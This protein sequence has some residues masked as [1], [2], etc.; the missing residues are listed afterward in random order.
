[1]RPRKASLSIVGDALIRVLASPASLAGSVWPAMMASMIVRPLVPMMSEITESSLILASSRVFCR[2]W[3]WLVRSRESCLRVRKRP[4][5][6]GHEACAD[7]AMRQQVGEPT[8]IVDVSLAA[9]DILDVGRIGQD[10]F[11]I[12]VAED[13]PNRLPVD[14]GRFHDNVRA[15]E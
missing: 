10:Q 1:M 7:Q 2:R 6:I 5:C 3:T 12:A 8:C 11:E 14:T 9:R 4:R 13:V 15:A